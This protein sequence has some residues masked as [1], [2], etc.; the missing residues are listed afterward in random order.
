MNI[1]PASNST[2]M[3]SLS[4]PH[5]AERQRSFGQALATDRRG[6]GADLEVD[7]ERE[8]AE[9]LIATTFIEP[10]LREAREVRSS[11]GPFGM[12]EAEKQFGSLMDTA[13]AKNMVR[14]W[15]FPMI[16][17]LARDMRAATG[18]GEPTA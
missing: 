1:T 2:W 13:T 5:L 15:D 17:R 14:S 16:D 11:D 4:Q 6:R 12:T 7:K 18:Q 10:M 8:A 3:P 9:Q